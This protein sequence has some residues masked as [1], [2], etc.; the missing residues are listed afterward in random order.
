MN[1]K[2]R[3]AII[4]AGHIAQVVHIPELKKLPSVEIAGICDITA[5][6]AKWVASKYNIAHH[7]GDPDEYF[8]DP[9]IDAVIICTPTHT[10]HDLTLSALS[11]G[12]HVLVEKP[13]ARTYTE[14]AAMRDAAEKYQRKLMVGMNVR[15]RRD[16]ITLKSF[17]DGHE[18]GDLLYVKSGWLNQRDLSQ[19]NDSWFYDPEQSG[20]GVMMDLGI[21]MLDVG[22]WLLGNIP[23]KSVKGMAFNR[24]KGLA[25][26]DSAVCMVHFENGTVLN[27]E[28]SW[29]L[30]TEKDLLYT[31]AYGSEGS[32]YINPLR[33]YKNLHGNLINI[34]PIKEESST[35]RYKR[36]Y[37]NELKHFVDCLRQN[38]PLQ[39]SAAES[40]ER[41]K[42]LEAFYQST[43][44][45]KE[46]EL[47]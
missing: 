31:N 4:G 12:K 21:Q 7:T 36:S 9:D 13:M 5:S 40:A 28:V 35:V 29:A 17:V 34:V 26:E 11:A 6:K 43:K 47:S 19:T 24:F 18:L 23:P 27:L 1:E 30:Y 3:F 14:A 22:W 16:A 8:R 38:M 2:L 15:F 25:V 32:A 20:G 10:H 44:E 33:V 45:G 39:A 37:R 42:I 41:L 46:V